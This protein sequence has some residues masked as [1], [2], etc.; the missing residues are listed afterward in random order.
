MQHTEQLLPALQSV[1]L[2]RGYD[3]LYTRD[4]CHQI[5]GF[6]VFLLENNMALLAPGW[7]VVVP[8]FSSRVKS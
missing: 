4:S 5:P 6:L 2:R 8:F 7:D 3:G 1:D